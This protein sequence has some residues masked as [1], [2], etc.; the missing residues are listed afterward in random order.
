MDS[1]NRIL[2]FQILGPVLCTEPSRLLQTLDPPCFLGMSV[3]HWPSTPSVPAIERIADTQ[4]TVHPTI[5]CK[6]LHHSVSVRVSH[7]KQCRVWLYYILYTNYIQIQ[8]K[9]TCGTCLMRTT[10]LCKY[11]YAPPRPITVN[12]SSFT[13]AL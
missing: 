11:K 6:Q 7:R 2:N 5:I 9:N 13:H 8:N 1:D 10:S 12:F 4:I 3:D